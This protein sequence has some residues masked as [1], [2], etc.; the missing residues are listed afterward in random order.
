MLMSVC[1]PLP[2]RPTLYQELVLNGQVPKN[3]GLH[4]V[5]NNTANGE[6]V[7]HQDTPQQAQQQQQQVVPDLI[8]M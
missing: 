7:Q 6:H 8:D 4:I 3:G 1:R 2:Q 5:T